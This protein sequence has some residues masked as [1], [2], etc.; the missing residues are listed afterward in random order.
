[1]KMQATKLVIWPRYFLHALTCSCGYV[2]PSST[3]QMSF[4]LNSKPVDALAIIVHRSVQDKI[5]RQ[6]VK[7][8]RM[9]HEIDY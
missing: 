4:L 9:C 1:M 8:L 3:S 2:I 7:K 5:G 6:W